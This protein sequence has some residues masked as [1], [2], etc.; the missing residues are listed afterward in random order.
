MTFSTGSEWHPAVGDKS[1]SGFSMSV[2]SSLLGIAMGTNI[3]DGI[4]L[5]GFVKVGAGF[6]TDKPGQ[7]VY[8]GNHASGRPIGEITKTSGLTA[9]G[10]VVRIVGHILDVSNGIIYFNPDNTWIEIA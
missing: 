10:D 1:T 4:L 3:T 7:S 8:L 5:R 9:T 6:G 2:S